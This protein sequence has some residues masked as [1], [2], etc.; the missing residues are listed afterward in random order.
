MSKFVA[1]FLSD[2][3]GATAVEYGLVIGLIA[4]VTVGVFAVLGGQARDAFQAAADAFA[5]G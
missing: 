3:S 2:E 1:R 4:L 5:G